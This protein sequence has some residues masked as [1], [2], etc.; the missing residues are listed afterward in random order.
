MISACAP[1]ILFC[2]GRP[3]SRA[4]QTDGDI[5]ALEFLGL[6]S[7]ADMD[8]YFLNRMR[9]RVPSV[10]ALWVCLQAQLLGVQLLVA[11]IKGHALGRK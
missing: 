5:G 7:I 4:P 8:P 1:R 10:A 9:A 11:T 3:F 2:E 6:E